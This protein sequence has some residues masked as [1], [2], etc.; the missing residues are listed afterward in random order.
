M[1]SKEHQIIGSKAYLE[2]QDTHRAYMRVLSTNTT[3]ME[4]TMFLDTY[5][6]SNPP[7]EAFNPLDATTARTYSTSTGREIFA[8]TV[9]KK[10]AK[11]ASK[12]TSTDLAFARARDLYDAVKREVMMA[13]IKES[14]SGV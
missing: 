12:N 10:S 3:A 13:L 6:P 1:E 5:F 4:S 2:L 8:P 11:S 9:E 7:F 14:E